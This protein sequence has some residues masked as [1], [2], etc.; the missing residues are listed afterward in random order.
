MKATFNME[1]PNLTVNLCEEDRARIDTIIELL[2]GTTSTVVTNVCT[3]AAP[4][5]QETQEAVAP[6]QPIPTETAPASP[7]PAQEQPKPAEPKELPP[8]PVKA[9]TAP[10]QSAPEVT[11]ADLQ[12][13]VVNLVSKGKKE[14]TRAIIME[15]APRVGE[16]PAEKR[17]EV[18]ERL[19]A[20]EG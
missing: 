18:L 10:T 8:E 20:L 5:P 1:V 7:Q 12:A 13:K 16:I 3:T 9:E 19:N 14:E 6:L 2:K 11:A 4:I 15:Y 17:A